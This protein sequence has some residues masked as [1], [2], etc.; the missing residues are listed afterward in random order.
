MRTT[1]PDPRLISFRSLVQAIGWLSVLL[2]AAM[3][4]GNYLFGGCKAIQDSVS[5]YYYTV[6]GDLLVGILCAVALFLISYKGYPGD[7]LDSILSTLA[8]LLALGVAF[9]PTNETSADS[10]A[11]I[12]LP[13]NELRNNLHNVFSA[14][15][16]LVLAAISLFQFTKSRGVTI[17]PRKKQRNHVYRICGVG[18]L[19]CIVLL[20]LYTNI[21]DTM[22]WLKPYK[23]VFWFESGALF[24]FGISWLVKGGLFLRDQK[25]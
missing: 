19:V 2:P 6:T 5:D 4:V 7:R 18:M 8:G 14:A 13:L 17:T 15:L 25:H 22:P 10:C 16:F 20:A 23:P 24:A 9:F 11:I 1:H 3:L 21:R 12:H